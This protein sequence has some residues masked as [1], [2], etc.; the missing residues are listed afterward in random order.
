MKT[1]KKL[2]AML[3][4]L[5][6]VFAL[7]ACGNDSKVE[8]EDKEEK[9][10]ETTAP[11]EPGDKA[12]GD[13]EEAKEDD[14]E[15][16]KEDAEDKKEEEEATEPEEKEL[17]IEG[18]WLA[19]LDISEVMYE[20]LSQSELGD[21]SIKDMPVYLN[22]ELVVPDDEK[23]AMS[24]I[25]DEDSMKAYM[26]EFM[27]QMFDYALEMA[28]AQ[29]QTIEDLEAE[30]GMSLEEAKEMLGEMLNETMSESLSSAFEGMSLDS[31]YLI[32]GNKLYLADDKDALGEEEAYMVISVEDD[33]LTFEEAVGDGSE[34]FID[35]LATYNAEFPWEFE[36]Q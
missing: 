26:A 32:D 34:D 23:L 15:E 2:L 27:D 21:I 35:Y 14:K 13:K 19:Q 11:V 36:R 1:W 7:A 20:S 25:F 24:V 3:M 16:T 31:Y 8:K 5:A 12:E 6:M 28:E 33:V 29:G 30:M 22:I 17:N 4:A 9:T 10:E 18:E